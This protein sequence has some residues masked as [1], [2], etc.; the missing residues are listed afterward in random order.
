[1]DVQRGNWSEPI[2]RFQIFVCL[3]VWSSS[4]AEMGF[5]TGFGQMIGVPQT[6]V[7]DR[8]RVPPVALVR[9]EK[10]HSLR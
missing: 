3:R 8:T 7:D 5:E 1:M 4:E 10:N 2:E 9:P 6:N